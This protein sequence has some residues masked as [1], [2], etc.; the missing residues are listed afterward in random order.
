MI[1]SPFSISIV[2]CFPSSSR[3]PGPTASTR[4]RCGFSLAVSGRTMP[5]LVVSSSSRASTMSRSPSGF[6]SIQPLLLK[7]A[8]YG[9]HSQV[10]SAEDYLSDLLKGGSRTLWHSGHLSAS[11][12]GPGHDQERRE[13]HAGHEGEGKGVAGGVGQRPANRGP[14]PVSRAPSGVHEAERD[15]LGKPG[16]LGPFGQEGH[17]RGPEGAERDGGGDQQ[18]DDRRGA[19]GEGE[20]H[21]DEDPRGDGEAEGEEA[22]APVGEAAQERRHDRLDRGAR[23]E[24]RRDGGGAPPG[25]PELER[26]EHRD[27]AEE[28]GRQ[29]HQPQGPD[30]YAAPERPRNRARRLRVGGHGRRLDRPHDERRDDRGHADEG[31]LRPSASALSAKPKARLASAIRTRPAST[32]RLGPNRAAPK[33]AGTAASTTPPAYAPTSRP[34]WP[35][36][37]SNSSA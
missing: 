18:H 31:R 34:A 29:H 3:G 28:E 4:P 15:R 5:L 32:A 33:P 21:R 23:D 24:G 2:M 25:A 12:G 8:D 1:S 14:E 20:R 7:L 27:Q 11:E 16:L 17:R 26:H 19:V 30:H 35:L 22:A 37:R 6:R 13:A 9:W 36:E 10:A